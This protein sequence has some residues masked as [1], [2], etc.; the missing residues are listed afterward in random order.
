MR[1][2]HVL[3]FSTDRDLQGSL[4]FGRNNPRTVFYCA[5]SSAVTIFCRHGR[6][7]GKLQIRVASR[8]PPLQLLTGRPH[9]VQRT[10]DFQWN[11]SLLSSTAGVGD[12]GDEKDAQPDAGKREQGSGSA[13]H[14]ARKAQDTD[15]DQEG[16]VKKVRYSKRYS[17]HKSQRDTPVTIKWYLQGL[18]V[19][20]RWT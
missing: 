7:R 10:L 15:Y 2:I 16:P 14:V 17:T 1:S 11:R 20:R 12:G 6:H 19:F 8:A 18:N 4:C 9:R 5:V 3:N 13:A